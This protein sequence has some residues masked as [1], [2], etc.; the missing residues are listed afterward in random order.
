MTTIAQRG[1]TWRAQ[2]R[3]E[4][5]KA[6]TATF[7]TKAQAQ[8]WARK[9]EAEMD[10]RGVM[11]A[12]GLANITLKERIDCYSEEIGGGHSFGENKQSQH[13]H[14][15]CWLFANVRSRSSETG[16]PGLRPDLNRIDRRRFMFP[17]GERRATWLTEILRSK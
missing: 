11:E 10:A 6:V 1:Q 2:I 13:E 9:I 15:H 5:H 4:S 12:R 17:A 14:G 7:P 8:A 16:C 3:R